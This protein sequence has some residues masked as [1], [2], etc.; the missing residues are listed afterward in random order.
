MSDEDVRPLDSAER[1]WLRRLERVLKDQPERLLLVECA[2]SLLLV[3]RER[4]RGVDIS[5]GGAE[6]AGVVLADVKHGTFKVTGVS[7]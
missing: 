3:D 7:G 1:R 5:D 2:D 6:R 4:A